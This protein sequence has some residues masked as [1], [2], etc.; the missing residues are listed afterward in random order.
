MRKKFFLS[1]L[2]LV[3]IGLGYYYL[4]RPTAIVSAPTQTTEEPNPIDSSS[5]NSTPDIP[6]DP[7][8][9]FSGLLTEVNTGCF[10]DGECY[11]V[12]AGKHVTTLLGRRQEVVGSVL[13]VEGFG[14]LEQYINS[15]VEVRALKLA[16]GTFTLYG[17]S[18]YYIKVIPKQSV[19]TK[20]TL[21][22]GQ[23]GAVSLIQITPKELIEDSRCPTDV[24][25]IQ[26]GTVRVR[27]SLIGTAGEEER[28]FVL[29]K[30]QN[31]FGQEII[32]ESVL[33]IKISTKSS[34]N[35]DYQFTFAL[36]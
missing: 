16:D 32:L 26:A 22:F 11:V 3:I 36:E 4:I 34:R 17:D 2:I 27:A 7:V 24:N 18:G 13:G 21:S 35:N 8:E 15:E 20:T 14:D 10:A 9:N 6:S 29:G 30:P 31:V 5:E 25:C 19:V 23:S 33:P 1:L 12:V 28:T